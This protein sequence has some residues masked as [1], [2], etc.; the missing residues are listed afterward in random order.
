MFPR[1]RGLRTLDLGTPGKLRDHLNALVMAGAK[2]ATAALLVHDYQAEHE[3][4]E[5]IG[6]RLVLVDSAGAELAEVE[7][8]DVDV[9]PMSAVTWEFAQAEGEGF[10]SLEHWWLGHLGY[11]SELGHDDVD[12]DTEI[13]CVHFRLCGAQFVEDGIPHMT[14]P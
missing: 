14:H 12:G 5:H 13:V 2:R 10:E 8:T 11:W 3:P 7:V 4:V 9:V 6:E 1:I